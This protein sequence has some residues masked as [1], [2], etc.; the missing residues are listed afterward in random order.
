MGKYEIYVWDNKKGC[1]SLK[2]TLVNYKT[3][4]W[5]LQRY[6]IDI[7]KK[8]VKIVEPLH[9]LLNFSWS[10]LHNRIVSPRAQ[11]RLNWHNPS[12]HTE[13]ETAITLHIGKY[14]LVFY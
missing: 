10:M 12:V 5:Q 13:F 6:T 2:K 9:F 3:T 4:I 7:V 8:G 11:A 1:D 14:P